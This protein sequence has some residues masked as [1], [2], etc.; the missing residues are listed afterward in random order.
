MEK[1]RKYK[2]DYDEVFRDEHIQ[3]FEE[4]MDK[5]PESMH[6]DAAVY[7]P[8]LRLSV[9]NLIR[10]LRRNKT[11]ATFSGYMETLLKIR[12]KLEAEGL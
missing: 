4:R 5:L 9:T 2:K 8:D 6:L 12:E 1:N 7:M 11:N 3:W 10:T